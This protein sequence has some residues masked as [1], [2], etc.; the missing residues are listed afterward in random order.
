MPSMAL[1][2]IPNTNIKS[3]STAGSNPAKPPDYRHTEKFIGVVQT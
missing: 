3:R 2:L 1:R